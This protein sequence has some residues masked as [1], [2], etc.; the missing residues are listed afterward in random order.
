VVT[1]WVP[2]QFI[3][4]TSVEGSPVE[5]SGQVRVKPLSSGETQ[6]DVQL[7]Y[8]PPGGVAGHTLASLLG[9]DPKRAM[10]EDL[11]RFKSLLETEQIT[12]PDKTVRLEEVAAGAKPARQRKATSSR[13]KR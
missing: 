4:W 13:K 2:G 7:A 3:G 6:V 5:T 10:D 11:A 8:H 12:T 9:V 1:D